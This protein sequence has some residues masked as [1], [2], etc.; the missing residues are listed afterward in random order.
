MVLLYNQEKSLHP[1]GGGLFS[2]VDTRKPPHGLGQ[3]QSGENKLGVY[4]ELTTKVV[5]TYSSARRHGDIPNDKALSTMSVVDEDF[6]IDP[7]CCG[8]VG[9]LVNHAHDAN[10]NAIIIVSKDKHV[11]IMRNRGRNGDFLRLHCKK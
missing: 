2:A 6:W 1:E 3:D 7:G 11:Y 10:N 4:P 8:G 5:C 9:Y